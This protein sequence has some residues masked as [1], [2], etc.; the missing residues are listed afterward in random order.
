MVITTVVTMVITM[1]KLRMTHAWRTQAAWAKMIFQL[2]FCLVLK[3]S[4]KYTTSKQGL[5]LDQTTETEH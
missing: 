5:G 2:K 4:Y 3:E 1:A